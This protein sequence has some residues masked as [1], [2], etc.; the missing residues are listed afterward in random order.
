MRTGQG[1]V[2]NI[3]WANVTGKQLVTSGGAAILG[4]AFLGTATGQVQL[5]AGTTA[6]ASMTPVI[7]FS[8]TTSAV[9][10]GYS[11]M[12]LRFPAEVSGNGL[13]IDAGATNDPNIQLFWSPLVKTP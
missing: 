11:P 2:A 5:F 3:F 10:G 4:I 1:E 12:F 6:S 8:V 9:A 13:V 7:T